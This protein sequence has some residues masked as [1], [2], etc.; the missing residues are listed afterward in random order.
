MN[1]DTT[2]FADGILLLG[3]PAVVL[4]P[5][6][7]EGLKRLGLASRWATLAAIIVGMVVGGGAEMIEIW[8]RTLPIVRVLLGGI[9]L[10]FGA[11]GVY[12]R[13]RSSWTETDVH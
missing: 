6:I 3:I 10:G 12:S 4:V 11:S 9:I 5:I 13:V 1:I 2:N 8:P 7:V